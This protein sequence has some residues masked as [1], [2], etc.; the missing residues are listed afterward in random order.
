MRPGRRGWCARPVDHPVSAE[1][2]RYDLLFEPVQVGPRTAPNRFWQTPHAT[3]FGAEFPGAMA[4]YRGTKAEGG[5]G[6]VFTEATSVAPEVDKSPYVLGR[7]WDE[8]DVR[9][10]RHVVD[11]IHAHGALAGTELEYHSSISYVSEG[12]GLNARG[13]VPVAGESGLAVPY[14]GTVGLLDA[15]DIEEV[16][17]LHVR[18]ALRARDAGFDLVT[19]HCGHAASLFAHFLIPYYNPRTDGYGGSLANRAR[20]ARETMERVREAVGDSVAVGLR[21]GV[22][23][24][25]EP[26][27][28]GDRGLRA[29]GDTPA[30]LELM[31]DLVDYWDFVIGG[32]DWGQDAQSSRT[33]GPNH[34]AR[35]TAGLKQYTRKPVVNVGRFNDPD[36][37]LEVVRSGQCDFVGAARASIADPFLPEKIRTGRVAE[38]RECIGCN[39]CVSRANV[40]NGRIVCTQNPTIGEEFRRGWHPERFTP[41]ADTE[42]PV[43]VVGAGPAGLECATVLGRRGLRNVHLVEADDDLGGCLGWLSRLPGRSEWRR[44]VEHRRTLLAGLP[45]VQVV[46]GTRLDA[47]RILDYGAGI[48]VLATGS[49]YARTGLNPYDRRSYGFLDEAFGPRL[50]TPE[51]VLEG[52]AA[53][54]DR[55]GDR[56]GE[57][58]LLLDLDGYAVGPGLAEHL[59]RAGHRVTVVTP[60][61]VFGGYLRLTM[62]H[63]RAMADLR[64]LGVEVR[65]GWMATGADGAQVTVAGPGG[66]GTAGRTVVEE[67]AVDG[68]LL[69]GQ[70]EAQHGLFRELRARRAEW[71]PNG[72]RAVYR[73]G[74]CVRPGFVAEAV[75]SGHRLAREIDAPDPADPLPYVRERRLVGGC[76]QD[77]DLTDGA[78]WPLH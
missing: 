39:L 46:T 24:L 51:D 76:D 1:A 12:R 32:F 28:L 74:D 54:G 37:M 29:D 49:R 69:V 41:A 26:F 4:G 38:I 64:D 13:V 75:F 35:W 14:A 73:V 43:L 25:D 8:G 9:N 10:W 22:D 66:P 71:E 50:L 52:E 47:D 65:T 78:H 58:V 61:E 18:A 68:V 63:T 6:V 59:A 53:A 56:L 60:A 11:A 42:T 33:A 57:R 44:V 21:L 2:G 40:A 19:F 17:R 7:M 72:L 31:D 55:P 20:F 70:R 45:G 23:T 30:F 62:E 15:D 16:Q 67:L 3:G 34:E 36:L 77:F 27:G 5:W 48:V